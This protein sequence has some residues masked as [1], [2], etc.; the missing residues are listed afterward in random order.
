[1]TWVAAAAIGGSAIIG[2]GASI[3]GASQAAKGAGKQAD[4]MRYAADLAAK[5]SLQMDENARADLSPFRELGIQSGNTLSDVMSGKANLTDLFK[6][7]SLY[8]FESEMGTRAIDR[9]LKARGAY[10]SGAGLET[11]ALFDKSLAASEGNAWWDKLY[12]T[13]VLGESAAAKMAAGSVQT[14]NTLAGLQVQAGANIGQAYANQ[15]NAYAAGAQ[16]AGNAFQD[17]LNN[18]VNYNINQPLNKALVNW[19]GGNTR[20]GSAPEM[21]FNASTFNTP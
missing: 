21:D 3:F 8:Q 20:R 9:Q 11:L 13:T 4:A 1:M 17:G 7:S 5:T 15:G 10:N 6:E 14:G 2:A 16:G 18:F 19:Y 12:N